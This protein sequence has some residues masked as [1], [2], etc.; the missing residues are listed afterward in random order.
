MSSQSRLYSKPEISHQVREARYFYLHQRRVVDHRL[1]VLC[2]GRETCTPDYEVDRP[3]FPY[4]GIEWVER[5]RGELWLK[6]RR[7]PLHPGAVFCYG[8]GVPHRI[9][10]DP[11]QPLTKCFLDFTGTEARSLLERA[12]LPPG[13]CIQSTNSL[14]FRE[15]FEGMY[16]EGTHPGPDVHEIAAAYL[17][18]L[19]LKTRAR[20]VR[21][22]R[23]GSAQLETFLRCR[24]FI[25]DQ[26]LRYTTIAALARAL[27]LTPS[28][29]CRLFREH[30]EISPYQ[31]L[32]RLRM[33]YALDRL[34]LSGGCVKRAC[35]EAGFTDPAHFSRLF[36]RVH[37]LSPRELATKTLRASRATS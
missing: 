25:Q 33:N 2:G 1:V 35:Y 37:G 17:R 24:Q 28:Y 31:F 14:D 32:L 29:L 10:T 21:S 27:G 3:T 26:F 7:Y 16:R 22:P 8:P 18:L 19:L 12:S 4:F 13:R 15:I 30:G 11:Q 34:L 6:E 9:R 36:K 20:R 5:G 23:N